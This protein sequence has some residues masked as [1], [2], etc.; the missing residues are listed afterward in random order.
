MRLTIFAAVAGMSAAGPTESRD[1]I[2]SPGPKL[3]SHIVARVATEYPV[4]G[5]LRRNRLPSTKRSGI[6][7]HPGHRRLPSQQVCLLCHVLG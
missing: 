4:I 1:A 7:D 2:K 6:A 3:S 5:A